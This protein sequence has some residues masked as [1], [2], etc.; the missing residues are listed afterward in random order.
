VRVWAGRAALEHPEVLAVGYFGSYARGDWGVGSDVDL[1][2][3]V[4]R[5][6][7][8]WERRAAAWDA[9]D[10]PVPAELFVY[11]AEEWGRLIERPGFHRAV[12]GEAVWV[13]RRPS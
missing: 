2:L 3:I 11:T 1:V 5:T 8:P 9:T 4:D 12:D 13:Y 10:L 7:L 6:E